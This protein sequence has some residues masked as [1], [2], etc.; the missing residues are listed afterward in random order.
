[1]KKSF[2]TV[3]AL[4]AAMALA[5]SCSGDRTYSNMLKV[6]DNAIGRLIDKNEFEILKNYP[7]DGV[8]KDN[9]FVI[10][11]NGVYLN[12]I[13]SGNGNHA[14]KGSTYIFCRF[15][16]QCLIEWQYMDTTTMDCFKNGTDPIIYRYGEYLPA[17]ENNSSIFFSTLLFSA[18][19]Y[20]GDNSE[21]KLII[22]FHLSG[23]NQ[24]FQ[25]AGVPLFFSKVRYRFDL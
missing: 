9:Q 12:V 17:E 15:Y 18:L 23:N 11:D 6:Q 10:L 22:P 7:S 21:V 14:V 8:F 5:L 13:D 24:T 2:N 19:E 16:V 25:S 1:M 20:V 4:C 3:L